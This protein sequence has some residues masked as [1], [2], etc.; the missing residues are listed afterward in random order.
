MCLICLRTWRPPPPCIPH[1]IL[2]QATSNSYSNSI[3]HRNRF[4]CE[5]D[6]C[7]LRWKS[8]CV[9]PK[10]DTVEK[11]T[12][13][14]RLKNKCK[15]PYAIYFHTGVGLSSCRYVHSWEAVVEF[16]HGPL[17]PQLY[18]SHW[19]YFRNRD[20]L[21]FYKY[22]LYFYSLNNYKWPTDVVPGMA[23]RWCWN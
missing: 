6:P 3:L 10:E 8:K 11:N 13:E 7:S 1:R 2:V 14:Q 17:Y 9:I 18:S 5:T 16:I 15:C 21:L 22:V 12:G 19:K 20:S 4:L 23:A